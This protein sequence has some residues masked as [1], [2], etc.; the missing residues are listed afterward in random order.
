MRQVL[1]AD[2]QRAAG[3]R[4]AAEPFTRTRSRRVPAPP[5]R[6]GI[7]CDISGSMR[8]FTGP[9]A[10]AAWILARA[11]SAL[12][13][14]TTATV[15]YGEQVHAL[16]HPGQ[17]PAQVTDFAAPDG[18]EQLCRAIDALDG[19]LGLSSP[20]TARLLAIVSDTYHTEPGIAGGQRRITRLAK[21]GCGVIILRPDDPFPWNEPYEWKNAQV[22]TL[23]DPADT[24]EVIARA[25]T[26]ALTA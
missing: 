1:A 13:A 22:I 7:A 4:P 24:I 20:G 14:A 25:A 10:S 5:L 6:V 15:L 19:A 26:R 3:A 17:A 16:T 9:V 23:T 12:P 21:T 11:A 18:T 2:A 8:A